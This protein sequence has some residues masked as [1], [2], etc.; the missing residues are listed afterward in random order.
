MLMLPSIFTSY[1]AMS[2]PAERTVKGP[3]LLIAAA[4][5]HDRFRLL[6]DPT[7]PRPN[8]SNRI[9]PIFN[10]SNF[11]NTPPATY[12]RLQQALQL[13][14][15]F[16][17][18]DSVLE[19]FVAPFLGLPL[20]DSQSGKTYLSDPL[21]NKSGRER[22]RL[23]G[24]V[25]RALDCLSH[26]INFHFFTNSAVRFYARTIIHEKPPAHNAYCTQHFRLKKSV[27]IDIRQ[28]Y[29]DFLQD[30]YASS[31]FCDVLRHDFSLAVALVH[32]VCHAVGVMRRGDLNEPHLRLDHLDKP[33]LGYAWEN[34][35]FGG[36]I[37][38][39]DRESSTISFLMRKIWQTDDKA[40]AA[41]G[42]E[43]AAV[44]VSYI[45]QWFQQQTWDIIAQHG[46]T[47]IPPP[48]VQL[49][50]CATP[51]HYTLL[52]D[53]PDVIVDV[54]RLQA[55][56]SRQYAR[57][58]RYPVQVVG[59]IT[60]KT[61][62]VSKGELQ[63]YA[64]EAPSRVGMRY[65]FSRRSVTTVKRTPSNVTTSSKCDTKMTVELYSPN[66]RRRS[67]LKRAAETD[68][69]ESDGN[70]SEKSSRRASKRRRVR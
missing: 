23:I 40:Y 33:E 55:H 24:E 5:K 35:I 14:S 12:Q 51:H 6:E 65:S 56:Y 30:R 29:W 10:P 32:E 7:V 50:L 11:G 54:A 26:S 3:Q 2:R 43:W 37:N 52:T 70:C 27:Q 46:P 48:V 61:R 67:Q 49:K 15:K 13:A 45:A 20:L 44:P 38:P 58:S 41:G 25:R 21:A 69:F 64:V 16:L 60:A 59:I 62:L 42:K 36:I 18:Y 47:A 63:I 66:T 9:H 1:A 34:F 4:N 53:N 22:R 17:E 31:S 68:D 19:W 57:A 39:F 8:I 28:Q